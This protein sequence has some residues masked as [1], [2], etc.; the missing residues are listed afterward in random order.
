MEQSLTQ[1]QQEWAA[2]VAR[3]QESKL[4]RNEFAA[5]EGI[6]GERLTWWRW[7]LKRLGVIPSEVATASLGSSFVRLEAA[8]CS[9]GV[10]QAEP[11]ELI[12]GG[13]QRVRIPVDF[14]AGTL[15]RVLAIIARGEA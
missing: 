11:L 2:R 15:T 14:D 4:G 6:A 9:A 5:R 13:G 1:T 3:W 8:E 12:L 7:K 10:E